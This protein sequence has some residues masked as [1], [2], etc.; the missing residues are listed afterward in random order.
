M[1]TSLKKITPS[2]ASNRVAGRA[3]SAG[4][5]KRQAVLKALADNQLR[6]RNVPFAPRIDREGQLQRR[7]LAAKCGAVATRHFDIRREYNVEIHFPVTELTILCGFLV[8]L[9]IE[10]CVLHYQERWA[11]GRGQDQEMEDRREPLLQAPS[12]YKACSS[13]DM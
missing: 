8:V 12:L 10:Q 3:P 4:W 6:L 5:A 1:K 13:Y 2:Q 7:V 11:R 9:V